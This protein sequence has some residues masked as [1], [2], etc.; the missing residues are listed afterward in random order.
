MHPHRLL[1]AV[2]L[3]ASVPALAWAPLG[4]RLVGELAEPQLTPQARAAVAELLAG[5]PEP[6]LGGVAYWADALRGN[7]PERFKATSS[8][9]YIG[10]PKGQ[11][12]AEL[13]RDCVGGQCV[14]AQIEAQ[15]AILADRARPLGER[16]DALKFLVHLVGDAHQPL[17]ASDQGD[18]GGNAFEL[19]LRTDIAPEAY[20]RA[21]YRD[22]VMQT[23]LHA[24]WDYYILESAHLDAHTYAATLNAGGWPGAPTSMSPPRA[25]AAESCR[26]ISERALYPPSK[27]LDESYLQQFRP[28]AE[29]RLRQAAYRLAHLLNRTL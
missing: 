13:A 6:T 1:V 4:H 29:Q 17:H 5:E 12:M 2:L 21:N 24:L 11:C 14:V 28:L 9:H 25:W 15:A 20:A 22:G 18:L 27:S 19:S 3:I 10:T 7:D 26:L 16:R 23:N 8:W